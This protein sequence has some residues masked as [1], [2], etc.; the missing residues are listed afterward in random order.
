MVTPPSLFLVLSLWLPPAGDL[1]LFPG[2]DVT[3]ELLVV[4]RERCAAGC[5]WAAYQWPEREYWACD[6]G[7]CVQVWDT[8]DDAHRAFEDGPRR[9]HLARL[10][11]LLGAECYNRGQLPPPIPLCWWR[12][13]E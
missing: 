1:S 10:R 13:C 12:K 7:F 4:A 6:V 8:L 9:W 11:G 2:R 3:A 5:P